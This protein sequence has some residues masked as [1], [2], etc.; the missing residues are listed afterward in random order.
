MNLFFTKPDEVPLPPNEVRIL[1]VTPDPYPEGRRVRIFMELTPFLLKPHGNIF[2]Y[3]KSGDLVAEASF[4]EAVSPNFEMV[5]HLR[6]L[7]P[8]GEYRVSITLYYME[9]IEDK[10]INDQT[11]LRSLKRIVDQ[12][13]VNFK[14]IEK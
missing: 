4:I 10:V 9:E 11:L 2:I 6:A 12:K 1:N 13:T 7:D 8:D 5:L 3:N 14:I